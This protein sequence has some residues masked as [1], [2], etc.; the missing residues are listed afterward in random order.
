MQNR[1]KALE[2]VGP[3]RSE[4]RAMPEE[5]R[6]EIGYALYLAQTGGKH[7]RTKPLRGV[8]TGVLEVVED[9]GGNTYRAVYTVRFDDAVYILH[10]FQ[11]KSRHGIE[12]PREDLELIRI[13]LRQVE[14][15]RKG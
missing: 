8:G 9:F 2:W 12:T 7:P 5:V 3:T 1:M 15:A 6:S 14:Q 13:R 11:K 10:V 4:L